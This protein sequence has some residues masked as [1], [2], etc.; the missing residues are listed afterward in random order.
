M[1]TAVL[2][3]ALLIAPTVGWAAEDKA[4]CDIAVI[5]RLVDEV[6]GP[7]P[8]AGPNEIIMRRPWTLRIDVDRVVM[9]RLS[10]RRIEGKVVA[11]GPPRR[12]RDFLFL[13][14]KRPDGG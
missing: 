13:L 10:S 14:R 9:G 8:V 4:C 1:R 6:P 5:G 2:A 3:A 11:H 7:A 12:D